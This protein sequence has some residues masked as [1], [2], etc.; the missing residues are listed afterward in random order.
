MSLCYQA[1]RLCIVKLRDISYI[2]N[3]NCVDLCIFVTYN[4]L[5]TMHNIHAGFETNAQA[6]M[7]ITNMAATYDWIGA[8][9][10]LTVP[11]GALPAECDEVRLEVKVSIC[12]QYDTGNFK[13]ASPVYWIQ[14]SPDVQFVKP[15]TVEIQHCAKSESQQP[16]SFVVTKKRVHEEDGSIELPYK[17]TK[18]EDGKFTRVSC[19]GSIKL[20]SFSGVAVALP[21]DA[22]LQLSCHVCS[23]VEDHS[24]RLPR[25][26]NVKTWCVISAN[27][28]V[29]RRLFVSII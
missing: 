20:Q 2:L 3:V 10:R 28:S 12:G 16:L 25:S 23:V 1:V 8:G 6:V 27:L 18:L 13:L 24:T 22:L 15:L 4:K 11:E 29:C 19:Y 17:F 7:T 5:Y 26:L 9:I 21:H 14:P